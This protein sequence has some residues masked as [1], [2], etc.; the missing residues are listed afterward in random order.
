MFLLIE[1]FLGGLVVLHIFWSY[2]MVKGLF[3]RLKSKNS[4]ES[5]KFG[6]K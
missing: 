4:E 2:L 1:T 6:K 5:D 3:I